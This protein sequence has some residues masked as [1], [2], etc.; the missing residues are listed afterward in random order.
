MHLIS[1]AFLVKHFARRTSVALLAGGLAVGAAGCKNESMPAPETGVDYYPIAVGN[2]WTYAVVDT[3]WSRASG[4][5]GGSQLIASVPRDST[6]QLKETITEILTD[7]AGKKAYRMV[8]SKR[9]GT[10]AAFRDDSVFVLSANEQFVTLN[11]NNARSVELIFPVREGRSWNFNAFNNN[12]NDTITAETRQYSAIGL[13]FTL[14]ASGGVPAQSYPVTVTT[15]NTGAAAENSL[16]KQASYRQ[17]F[18]KGVGPVFRRRVYFLPYTYVGAG[19]IQVYP[20]RAY[21]SG[22]T[23]RETLI[24]HGPR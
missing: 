2:Y 23:R 19:G 18:A 10:T 4:G 17:V 9:V 21:V 14:A 13:P 1:A 20:P 15:A 5:V 7:A 16:V 3:T 6:Y 24:D 8:R 12:F 11:R 22:F